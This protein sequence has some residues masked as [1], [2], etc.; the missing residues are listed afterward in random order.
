MF[1]ELLGWS[2]EGERGDKGKVSVGRG[3]RVSGLVGVGTFSCE[4][5][6]GVSGE[7]WGVVC[8]SG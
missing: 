5:K 7:R 1:V 6:L 8:V 2:E 3:G 4:G